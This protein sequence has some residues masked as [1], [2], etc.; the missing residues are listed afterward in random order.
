MSAPTEKQHKDQQNTR[1]AGSKPEDPKKQ[2]A[3]GSQEM[4]K[5]QEHKGSDS[6]KKRS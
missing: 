2:D 3:K 1:T 4:H 5:K 6:Q